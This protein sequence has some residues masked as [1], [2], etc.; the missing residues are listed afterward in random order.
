MGERVRVRGHI[1][2]CVAF[3]LTLALICHLTGQVCFSDEGRCRLIEAVPAD[4]PLWSLTTPEP[5][6]YLMFFVGLSGSARSEIEARSSAMQDV[7]RQVTDYVGQDI[8][9]SSAEIRTRNSTAADGAIVVDASSSTAILSD[10][11]VSRINPKTWFV[12]RFYNEEKKQ[13]FWTAH[14][15]AEVPR[16]ELEKAILEIARRRASSQSQYSFSAKGIVI[17]QTDPAAS[18]ANQIMDEIAGYLSKSGIAL[19]NAAP[20][21]GP[22]PR[23]LNVTTCVDLENTLY[24][25]KFI[26]ARFVLRIQDRTPS[27]LIVTERVISD[28]KRAYAR[29]IEAALV[30]AVNEFLQ[31]YGHELLKSVRG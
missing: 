9:R 1:C 10:A 5:T 8:S 13:E 6:P 23:I 18:G 27:G 19:L 22:C 30:L 29:T 25:R 7:V 3:I 14:V 2:L 17:C 31:E 12:Q 15:L 11:F 16:I 21:T 20:E 26:A 4:R 24:D 28:T